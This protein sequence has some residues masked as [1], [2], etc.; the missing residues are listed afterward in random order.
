MHSDTFTLPLS[1][2]QE[3]FTHVAPL[4]R[5]AG[6]IARKIS[7]SSLKSWQKKDMSPVTEADMA[8]NQLLKDNLTKARP[9][10]IWISEED[11]ENSHK[12]A[13]ARL[14]KATEGSPIYSWCLDPIDGTRGFMEGNDHWV[15]SLAVLRN[16]KPVLGMVFNPERD[17]LFH[18]IKGQGSFVNGT[19]LDLKNEVKTQHPDHKLK[20][21]TRTKL[22]NF[23]FLSPFL[24]NY[25]ISYLSSLAMRICMIA[26]DKAHGCFLTTPCSIWDIAAAQLILEEAGGTSSRLDLSDLQMNEDNFK[27]PHMILGEQSFMSHYEQFLSDNDVHIDQFRQSE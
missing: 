14:A 16:D 26:S 6:E 7:R 3:D 9:N 11:D 20:V 1:N 22:K 23:D 10:Y 8:V 17:Q 25:K 2:L 15:I 21:Y 4:I 19:R 18:T 12:I 13:R 5:E 24:N 27:I